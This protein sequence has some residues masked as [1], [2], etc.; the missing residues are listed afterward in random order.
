MKF[1]YATTV[2]G[3]NTTLEQLRS[4]FPTPLTADTLKKWGIAQNNESSILQTLRFIRLIDEAG[5]KN[6]DA[7]QAFVMH[8]NVEFGQAFGAIV[9][10]AYDELFKLHGE[11]GAWQL[12]RDK[13]ITFFRQSDQTSA[14]VGEQQA[15][16]FAALAAFAGHSGASAAPTNGSGKR[17]PTQKRPR[18]E[19][20]ETPAPVAPVVM[21]A[22]PMVNGHALNV[23]VRVELNLPVADDQG[24]Y[25]RIFRSIRENLIND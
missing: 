22:P 8:D 13:L 10:K 21:T 3:L 24:V 16:T 15:A 25:D 18:A 1:P 2:A 19:R 11:S 9:R 23:S 6:A 12:D 20:K 14:R 4:A 5:N 7:A 17:A